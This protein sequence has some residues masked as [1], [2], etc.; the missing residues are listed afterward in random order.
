LFPVGQKV[1]CATS[2]LQQAPS[3][4]DP[5]QMADTAAKASQKAGHRN[6]DQPKGRTAKTSQKEGHRSK[7]KST[8]G[9]PQQKI[10]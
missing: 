1:F 2:L 6:K 4:K 10:V 7:D 5:N 9:T 3:D 8:G